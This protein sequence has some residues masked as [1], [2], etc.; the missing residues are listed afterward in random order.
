MDEKILTAIKENNIS[1]LEE[2]TLSDA[3]F[4]PSVCDAFAA[5]EIKTLADLLS[6]QRVQK[7]I[8]V[9]DNLKDDDRKHFYSLCRKS[10]I[11][12]S[13]EMR[14]RPRIVQPKAET[15]KLLDV[16]VLTEYITKVTL[17][18]EIAWVKAIKG[19]EKGIALGFVK[20]LM[21]RTNPPP[22]HR[23][24]CYYSILNG[25]E[26]A[27][28]AAREHN[29]SGIASP[30]E[31]HSISLIYVKVEYD[32]M[33]VDA[34]NNSYREC[35]EF[36]VYQLLDE[37]GN[38]NEFKGLFTIKQDKINDDLT[39]NI[40]GIKENCLY[41]NNLASRLNTHRERLNYN[42]L[43]LH[44]H[45]VMQKH[46][47]FVL[48]KSG[49][50]FEKTQSTKET[51]I[52]LQ[53]VMTKATRQLFDEANDEKDIETLREIDAL[54]DRK[55]TE[56]DDIEE[57]DLYIRSFN[58]LKRAKINTIA[59][60]TAMTEVDL[61]K[62]RNLGRKSMEEIITV[63]FAHGYKIT[64]TPDEPLYPDYKFPLYA[65][66]SFNICGHRVLEDGQMVKVYNPLAIENNTEPI[67]ISL[68]EASDISELDLTVRAFN[69][70]YRKGCTQVCDVT[71]LTFSEMLTVRNLGLKNACEVLIKLF[72]NGFRIKGCPAEKFET[73]EQFIVEEYPE[74]V[75]RITT[76]MDSE[77]F[78]NHKLDFTG[79]KPRKDLTSADGASN[80]ISTKEEELSAREAELDKRQKEL[81][82]K[83]AR[84]KNA[85]EDIATKARNLQVE[86]SE[87]EEK[88][89]LAEGQLEEDR[90]ILEESQAQLAS[91]TETYNTNVALL[92]QRQAAFEEWADKV[93]REI[94]DEQKRL[95][96][97]RLVVSLDAIRSIVES[98]F[99][100]ERASLLK[101]ANEELERLKSDV[102]RSLVAK[103]QECNALVNA[104]NTKAAEKEKEVAKRIEEINAIVI[105]MK[106]VIDSLEVQLDA[107][108]FAIQKE[109]VE[110]I[111]EYNAPGGLFGNSQKKLVEGK[112]AQIDNELPI[113]L[114]LKRII[115]DYK[116]ALNYEALKE[117]EISVT[118]SKPTRR[119]ATS[120]KMFQFLETASA[121]MI[122]KY[123]GFDEETIVIPDTYNGKPVTS[124][125]V[126]AFSKCT[127][128]K[129]VILG[130]N[131]VAIG[132]SAF[133]QCDKLERVVGSKQI[134][135]IQ[136]YAF[137]WC[138]K[139][140]EFEFGAGLEVLEE[141]AFYN[142]GLKRVVIPPK[143]TEIKESVFDSCEKIE[144]IVFHDKVVSIGIKA[145]HDSEK[146]KAIELPASVRWVAKTAFNFIYLEEIRVLSP[147]TEFINMGKGDSFPFNMERLTVYCHPNSKAQEYFRNKKSIIKP[148]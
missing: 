42:T 96:L 27:D 66:N 6:C 89:I 33:N 141:K 1:E 105:A 134:R 21:G 86:R 147:Y 2:C 30:Y 77:L 64:T 38:N 17:N 14:I 25:K 111:S 70:L 106:A 99:E 104:A 12:I 45:I 61:I 40:K 47:L 60:L 48:E 11:R 146:V 16:D 95:A 131:V 10:N 91:D 122:E 80:D 63:L 133:Y 115:A 109:K 72:D 4:N 145:F 129:Q 117:V 135:N 98:Q 138:K 140:T 83:E 90:R 92:G 142:T 100:E 76:I 88:R 68:T 55:I 57:L 130:K 73:L 148:I 67:I 29:G 94:E 13:E 79:V 137:G 78:E 20:S 124:I 51:I 103:V 41:F 46:Y 71:D 58:C 75:E 113:I 53:L 85:E 19:T 49:V 97:T 126:D 59:E 82:E 31:N 9:V 24:F 93:R 7:I 107:R 102:Q 5:I 56:N 44:S 112:L 125:G 74:L 52:K 84:L 118:P 120:A 15:K 28:Y 87:Y 8:S 127:S 144:S 110:L 69:C 18:N 108:I 81:D 22:I 62:V 34:E 26:Y 32:L 123:I 132:E 143:I 128:I 119:K 121:A 116:D 39:S 23:I 35:D 50:Q 3:G 37:S 43:R 65:N 54:L 36:I 136:K 101:S 114:S 139:L